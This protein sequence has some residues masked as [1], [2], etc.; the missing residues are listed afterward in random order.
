M[1]VQDI[2]GFDTSRTYSEETKLKLEEAN[3][4]IYSFEEETKCKGKV[5][6]SDLKLAHIKEDND[7]IEDT[8]EKFVF[9]TDVRKSYIPKFMAK[10]ETPALTGAARGTVYHMVMK[11]LDFLGD[12]SYEGIVR[13]ME[14]MS[15]IGYIPENF[16]EIVSVKKIMAFFETKEGK[17]MIEADRQGKLYKEKQFV[18]GLPLKEVYKVDS[19]ELTIIQG[20]IDVYYEKDDKIY[21]LDYKTDAVSMEDGEAVLRD[22]Y[23]LQLDYYKKAIEGGTSLPVEKSIIYSFSM[24][25]SFEV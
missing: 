24:G 9:E 21:L 17:D 20:I 25:K 11:E 23:K 19:T 10:E 18:M 15:R 3:N 6:V 22:R 7:K 13:Q 14:E 5:S 4:Y 1:A 8:E 12:L 2:E 16:K